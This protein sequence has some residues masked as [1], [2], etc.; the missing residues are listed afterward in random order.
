[1]RAL[2]VI[3]VCLLL[4]NCLNFLPRLLRAAETTDPDVK[5]DHIE[6][7]IN[8]NVVTIHIYPEPNRT[9]ILEAANLPRPRSWTPIYTN[10]ALP[11]P[12]QHYI[13]ADPMTNVMRYYRLQAIP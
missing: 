1:M 2:A 11:F 5:I 9:Y 7:L 3:V 4:A 10:R 8:A 13:Y 6:Y 12:N